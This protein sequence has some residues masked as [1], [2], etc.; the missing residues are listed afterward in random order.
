MITSNSLKNLEF[1]NFGSQ[2]GFFA[3]H[4]FFCD[5][6]DHARKTGSK[7]CVSAYEAHQALRMGLKY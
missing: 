1:W 3:L 4:I 7:V 5:T 2:L 6:W